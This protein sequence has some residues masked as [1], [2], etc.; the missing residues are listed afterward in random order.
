MANEEL[1]NALDRHQDLYITGHFSERLRAGERP[2]Y[3]YPKNH[4]P[5]T[6]GSEMTV[7]TGFIASLEKAK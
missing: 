5:T 1:V 3:G 4:L 2:D 7:V 6:D